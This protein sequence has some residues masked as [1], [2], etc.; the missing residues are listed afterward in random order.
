MVGD[1]PFISIGEYETPTLPTDDRLRLAYRRL[2]NEII[3]RRRE[4]GPII[5]SD[6]LEGIT[7]AQLDAIVAPPAYGKLLDELDITFAP[8]LADDGAAQGRCSIILPPCES[9]NLIRSWA[10]RHGLE[11]LGAPDRESILRG[12]EPKVLDL[13]GVGVLVIP[14]LERWFLRHR[15]GLTSI[16]RLFTEISKLKRRVVIGCNSWACTYLSSAIG[17]QF[18]DAVTFQ[19]FD[20]QR[21]A[22]WFSELVTGPE[23]PATT[24]RL[25]TNGKDAFE[26]DHDEAFNSEFLQKLAA[27]SLGIP[28]VAWSLWR[29]GLRQTRE[30]EDANDS[31]SSGQDEN[32]VWIAALENFALPKDQRQPALLVLQSLLI[33]GPMWIDH[34]RLTIPFAAQTDVVEALVRAGIVQLDDD[35]LTCV[36]A[37]YP[38]VRLELENAGFS[39]DKL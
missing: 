27:H 3:E 9:D 16:R 18:P 34:L 26:T 35:C 19:A 32:T 6:Q 25:S 30:A 38:A 4:D 13:S 8:W 31:P 39:M 22:D 12:V 5:A 37:A 7:A 21:L 10:D 17:L 11:C 28:W 36:A 24:F 23:A 2:K 20:Q 1:K 29:R 15:N 14:D 33:H